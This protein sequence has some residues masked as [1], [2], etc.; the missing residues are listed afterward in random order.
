MEALK[1]EKI[2]VD[3]NKKVYNTIKMKLNG[4]KETAE[5]LT[6]NVFVKISRNLENFKPELSSFDTW[7]YNITKNVLIDYFRSKQYKT[8]KVQVNFETFV[9]SEG[10]ELFPVPDSVN[11]DSSL[12]TNEIDLIIDNTLNSMKELNQKVCR[13]NLDGLKMSEIATEL[14][15]PEGT[16]K[17]YVMRFKNIVKSKLEKQNS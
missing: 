5:D 15:I 6:I 10:N 14:S 1:F 16:V 2:Y 11:T 7:I 12:L 8:K 17:V 9:D 3:Y 4:D 13:M